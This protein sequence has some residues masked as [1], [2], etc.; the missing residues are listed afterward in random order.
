MLCFGKLFTLE[1]FFMF[2][3]KEI[4]QILS[5]VANWASIFYFLNKTVHLHMIWAT[6]K[7]TAAL[8]IRRLCTTTKH[9]IFTFIFLA[10][11]ILTRKIR[12]QILSQCG[13]GLLW[14]SQAKIRRLSPYLTFIHHG[15][16]WMQ[17]WCVDLCH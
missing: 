6:G 10:S 17:P 12:H 5:N 8:A 14:T 16:G 11:A 13:H 15:S 2:P 9:W 4:I 1:I 7:I 3:C